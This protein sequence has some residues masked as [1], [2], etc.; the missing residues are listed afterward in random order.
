MTAEEVAADE[1]AAGLPRDGGVVSNPITL[2]PARWRQA[3][4]V[5][6]DTSVLVAAARSRSG[7]SYALISAIPSADFEI[8]LAVGLLCRMA[9]CSDE[10]GAFAAGAE[11]GERAGVFALSGRAGMVAGDLLSVVA[12]SSRPTM[13]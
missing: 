2:I 9:G 6:F 4:R 3:M 11:R 5:A 12:V 13:I 7:A 10:A 8:C 1:L